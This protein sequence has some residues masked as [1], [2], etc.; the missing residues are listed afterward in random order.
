ML[1]FCVR[2]CRGSRLFFGRHSAFIMVAP[3]QSSSSLG[4][5]NM[6]RLN[7]G[8]PFV[9]SRRVL[10]SSLAQCEYHQEDEND[11]MQ[12]QP[13]RNLRRH[14]RPS[15]PPPPRARRPPPTLDDSSIVHDDLGGSNIYPEFP[16]HHVVST[17]QQEPDDEDSMLDDY[18]DPNAEN[19]QAYG[20]FTT[21]QKD[22]ETTEMDEVELD[23]E[24]GDDEEAMY[25]EPFPPVSDTYFQ[26]QHRQ[27]EDVPNPHNYWDGDTDSNGAIAA[28][29]STNTP[30]KAEKSSSNKSDAVTMSLVEHEEEE[31]EENVVDATLPPPVVANAANWN[32]QQQQEDETKPHNYR[33]D[34][35]ADET[36]ISKSPP[37]VNEISSKGSTAPSPLPKP[38]MPPRADFPSRPPPNE[39]HRNDVY[40]QA[41]SGN[42]ITSQAELLTM[43]LKKLEQEIYAQNNH[44]KFNIHSPK[45]VSIVL[46]GKEGQ[47]TNKETLEAMGGSGRV[48]A[49]LILQHRSLA[50]R[51]SRLGKRQTDKSNGTL[52]VQNISASARPFT[53]TRKRNES[54]DASHNDEEVVEGDPLLLVDA[55]AYIWRAYYSMPPLHRK[56]GMPVGAVLGFC[57][58]L[59]RL[60]LSRMLEG[61]RPRLVLVFDSKGKTFRHDL[62]DEYKAN[63][64]ECPMDLIPQFDLIREAAEAYGIQQIEASNFEADDVIAT[65]AT[66][67]LKEG[68]DANILSGDKDLMQLITPQ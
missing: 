9:P 45:Q 48:M 17:T 43:Q 5:A 25:D 58:M 50:R 38:S 19:P 33:G 3:S 57:N 55:S 10:C 42:A 4:G 56:D 51:I 23:D 64:K 11:G 39:D 26:N 1:S 16:S 24:Q 65:L 35:D 20:F 61:E 41:S 27:E 66:M 14:P 54:N 7:T 59:N 63:R 52:V 28:T 32:N 8:G 22:Y 34:N 49:D 12:K 29:P 53:P 15:L 47:S 68:V 36:T 44:E 21:H 31:E 46:F 40:V 60:V 62:Y 30:F 67:A 37:R 18:Y 2:T 6:N 13:Q